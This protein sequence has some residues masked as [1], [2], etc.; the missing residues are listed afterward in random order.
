M[1]TPIPH[2]RSCV[3]GVGKSTFVRFLVNSLLSPRVSRAGDEDHTGTGAAAV[4]VLDLDLGQP[5]L[6]PPGLLSLHIVRAPLLTPPHA[7][8][9]QHHR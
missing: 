7:H 1:L 4:A 9:Q 3:Q 6:G 5:E 8:M 2:T